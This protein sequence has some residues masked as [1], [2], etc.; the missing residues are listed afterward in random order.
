MTGHRSR[1]IRRAGI[2][3][4]CTALILT[5]CGT[6]RS[7]LPFNPA[8]RPA[9]NASPTPQASTQQPNRNCTDPRRSLRPHG[10]LP[11]PG[12]IPAGVLPAAVLKNRYLRVGVP[13][14][15]V[16]LGAMNWNTLQLEGFDID[17]AKQVAKAIF[18]T[19]E[20]RIQF[21][22]VT[23][24]GRIPALEND[25]VDLVVATMTITC[26][27]WQKVDFSSVYYE[28]GQKLLVQ[29]DAGFAGI[30]D[31]AGRKICAASGSTSLRT[32]TRLVPTAI[33][34]EVPNATDCLV[35]LQR[36]QIDGISTDDVIL[37]GMAEQDP[38]T[39]I[40]GSKLSDEPYGMAVKAG[41]EEFVRFIN[42]ALEKMRTDGTWKKIYQRW[43]GKLGDAS[44][45]TATY[46][47]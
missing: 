38:T 23:T 17:M 20:G 10:P 37:A 24:D 33:R 7:P 19:D 44:P 42:A 9:E 27:R 45:P 40:V 26:D 47:D 30:A 34:V 15:A 5:A 6:T 25:D 43:L 35:D 13:T 29:Q 31:L 21:R 12:N 39:V 3:L 18:G 14:D 46:Q 1:R 4:A 36:G 16:L 2:L 41:N 11:T 22:A 28:S 8:P 32:I